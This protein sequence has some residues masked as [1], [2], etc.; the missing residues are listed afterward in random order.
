MNFNFLAVS[1]ILLTLI[2][3][4][5][6]IGTTF[7]ADDDKV[8]ILHTNSGPLVIEFFPD[9]APNTVNNFLKLVESGFY[10]NTL[11]HRIIKN[12]MIQGGDPL[13]KY[14]DGGFENITS[15]GTGDAGYTIP[16]EFNDIKHNR[17]IVSMARSATYDSGSSQFFIIQKDSNHLDGQYAV[18]G[19]LLTEESYITLDKIANLETTS[20]DIPNNFPSAMIVKAEIVTR[21]NLE[22]T[23]E[24]SP[25]SITK[26]LDTSESTEFGTLANRY[27]SEK[28]GFSVI[29][30]AGWQVL[31]PEPGAG[32]N[33]PVITFSSPETTNSAA[34]N[35][36]A[37]IFINV[38]ELGTQTFQEFLDA[39]ANEYHRLHELGTLVIESEQIANLIAEDNHEYNSYILFAKQQAIRG[40]VQF[41]QVI[42][43]DQGFAYG[44]SYANHE[45]LFEKDLELYHD[46]V[47]S[48]A[49]F[50]AKQADL[51]F[52]EYVGE[53]E[54]AGKISETL[55][56]G[57]T[58]EIVCDGDV[59]AWKE[60]ENDE[61]GPL[62]QGGCLIATAAFGSELAPQVQI[63][64]EIRDNTVL[65]TESGFAFMTGFNQFY[66]S[67]SPIVADYERE[68]PIFKEVVKIT[69]T[70]LLASLTLLQYADIDSESDMLMYGIGIILLNI[71]IYFVAP[72]SLIVKVRNFYKLQ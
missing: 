27:V 26:A 31:Y 66:Y 51:L 54:T 10:D 1:L 41:A 21:A 36:P 71:G 7:A 19:R 12:F 39:R 24:L 18:F 49:R 53:I 33:D 67:F 2:I 43:H 45:G 58:R 30:P 23:L 16:A 3:S 6:F 63:L 34:G 28:Y 46:V 15:W 62:G 4:P 22:T 50:D 61:S 72:A 38:N 14:G 44:I 70:P 25:P 47:A 42:F 52:G 64:R 48:F 57:P 17:G 59:C 60:V 8:V 13:T 5:V 32:I 35:F 40:W 69:L 29:P 68:N 9:D 11:F 20:R 37:F 55:D 65:Q 56:D